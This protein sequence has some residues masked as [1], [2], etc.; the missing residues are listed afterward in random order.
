MKPGDMVRVNTSRVVTKFRDSVW[1]D[2]HEDEMCWK[3]TGRLTTREIATVMETVWTRG[4]HMV[5]ILKSS[6]ETG[7]CY[8]SGLEVISEPG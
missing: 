2:L 1:T 7:W 3:Y 5:R 6:G 8:A 4:C